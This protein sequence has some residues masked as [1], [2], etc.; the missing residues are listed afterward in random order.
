MASETGTSDDMVEFRSYRNDHELS[1][2]TERLKTAV[3]QAGGNTQVSI[4]SHVPLNTLNRYIAG[5]EMKVSALVALAKACDV[6]VE[7][8]AN[9][10]ESSAVVET[11]PVRGSSAVVQPN[12]DDDALPV[13]FFE[14][15]P[16]AGVGVYP[17]EWVD[18]QDFIVSKKFIRQVL[19]VWS[20]KIFFVRVQGDSMTPTIRSGETILVDYTPQ[21]IVD[22]L[23]M[24]SLHGR[25]IVKRLS[26]K[27]MHN[28]SVISDNPRY[29]TFDVPIKKVCWASADPDADLRVVGKVVGRFEVGF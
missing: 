15:E 21:D 1:E 10:V 23:F 12:G 17:S 24:L 2:R 18:S 27:D 9:G 8:L 19:G 13:K 11:T 6:S 25:L 16:S 28:I 26:I 29:N 7:W 3:R 22:G 4:R 5:R 20:S 14:V